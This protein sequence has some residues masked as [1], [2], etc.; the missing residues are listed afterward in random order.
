MDVDKEKR[1][2]KSLAKDSTM[3]LLAEKMFVGAKDKDNKS[4][5]LQAVS[6]EIG[7]FADKT[8]EAQQDEGKALVQLEG[9]NT[10]IGGSKTQLYGATTINAKT[11]I[12]DELK[13][14]KATIDNVEAKTSFKSSNISDGIPVPAPPS[15][16]NLSAKLKTEDAPKDDT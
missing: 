7:L 12:K 11:E 10:S 15:S 3:L 4:K 9:G 14:P 2:D 1:T 5:K 13:A 16:A 6:E 8:F